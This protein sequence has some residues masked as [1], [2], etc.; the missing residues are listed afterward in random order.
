VVFDPVAAEVADGVERAGSASE[1]LAAADAAVVAS[2]TRDHLEQTRTALEAGCHV[3]CEKPLAVTLTG[4]DDVIALAQERS[5]LLAV[6]MNLRFHPGP[7]TVHE[8][9][10]SGAIGRPLTG[11]FTFGYHL[12]SWRP[13]TDYRES[14]SARSEL[15]GGVLLDVIHEFD[16]AAWI[17]GPIGEV[18]GWAERVSALELDVEDVALVAARFAEGAIGTFTL[19]YLD[20]SYRRGCRIVGEE[21]SVRWS[22][23]DG[24]IELLG[25]GGEAERHDAPSAVDAS[26]ELEAAAFVDAVRGG[27]ASTEGTALVSA[28]EGRAALAVVQAIRESVASGGTGTQ[29]PSAA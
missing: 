1:A 27:S 28:A 20:R 8:L 23:R 22:W 18:S 24:V 13:G 4:V 11:H 25:P 2:P 7:R 10:T 5:L 9:V 21:G 15:G 12:P 6:A 26:Y 17:L 16:Y 3:L 19:D 29:V 14:Y